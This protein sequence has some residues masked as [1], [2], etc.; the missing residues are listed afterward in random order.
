MLESLLPS[1]LVQFVYNLFFN[2]NK[3]DLRFALMYQIA[4]LD[5]S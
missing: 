2:R 3:H 4:T 1:I 5:E